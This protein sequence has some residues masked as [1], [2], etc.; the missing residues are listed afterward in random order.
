MF[1]FVCALVLSCFVLSCLAFV[2]LCCRVVVLSCV[3]LLFVLETPRFKSSSF[4][5][6]KEAEINMF[7]FVC[8]LVLYCFVLSCL[9]FVFLCCRVVV[10]SCVGLLFVLET[11]RFKSSSFPCK[12]QAEI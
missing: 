5:C 4:P 2:F 9:A 12:K 11:P 7:C 10:L 6:E 1:C 3:G 8:A